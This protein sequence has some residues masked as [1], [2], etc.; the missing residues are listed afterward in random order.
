M[1]KIIE[2]ATGPDGCEY[3][4]YRSFDDFIIRADGVELM[5]SQCHG[6]EEQL[7]VSTLRK[8]TCMEGIKVLVG[9]LGMGFTIKRL[10]GIL[11]SASSVT[12]VEINSDVIN[13]NRKYFHSLNGN[14]LN[15]DRV[16]ML[17]VDIIDVLRKNED[18][19]DIFI[20]D[21]DNGP[22]HNI[23]ENNAWLY[24]GQGLKVIYDVLKPEGVFSLWSADKYP[25]FVSLL[26]NAGFN[27]TVEN[28]WSNSDPSS[29]S[30]VIFIGE[31]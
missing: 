13:W 3:I 17:N 26:E 9:G 7:A 15:D 19:Y 1:S 22:A 8:H 11:P 12:V 2:T 20:L 18:K 25:G 16:K 6:S 30:Y 23:S 24:T 29:G 27:V 28:T 14:A 10:L 21:V 31:K 4:L 5:T